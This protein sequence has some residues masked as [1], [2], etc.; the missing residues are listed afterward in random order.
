MTFVLLAGWKAFA[1]DDRGIYYPLHEGLAV[2]V[3]RAVHEFCA[4]RVRSGTFHWRD[5]DS[6]RSELQPS[7]S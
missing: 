1:A 7:G 5:R 4:G 2:S 3:C 6:R